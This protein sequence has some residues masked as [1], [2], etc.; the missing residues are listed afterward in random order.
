MHIWMRMRV[1]QRV[2]HLAVIDDVAQLCRRNHHRSHS[3][4]PLQCTPDLSNYRNLLRLLGM[5]QEYSGVW[6]LTMVALPQILA[7]L[8]RTIWSSRF[9]LAYICQSLFRIL[10]IMVNE[11]NFWFSIVQYTIE[12]LYAHIAVDNKCHRLI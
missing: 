5:V 10:H 3:L 6:V 2:P 11:S 4:I 8:R 7:L 9:A 12:K 1:L